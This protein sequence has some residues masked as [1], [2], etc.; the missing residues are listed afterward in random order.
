[1]S[2]N[3]KPTLALNSPATAP[4]PPRIATAPAGAAM[5]ELLRVEADAR[6]VL[7]DVELLHLAV[8]DTRRLVGARQVFA[9]QRPRDRTF[10]VKSRLQHRRRRS[11]RPAR[12]LGGRHRE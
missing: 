5:A 10:R 9:V 7:R 8:N 4:S 6:S 1:M 2:T 3:V 12:A 11:R